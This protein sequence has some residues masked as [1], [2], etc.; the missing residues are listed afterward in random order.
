MEYHTSSIESPS[1]QETEWLN[2]DS[3]TILC[4]TNMWSGNHLLEN[5][6]YEGCTKH[7]SEV[8]ELRRS[9]LSK[10]QNGFQNSV[11]A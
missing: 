7:V 8:A 9:H 3:S 5:V 2:G 10:P 4:C 11:R 1:R 6:E